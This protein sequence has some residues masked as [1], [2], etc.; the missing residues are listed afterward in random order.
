MFRSLMTSRRFA[1]LF[2]C[3]FFAAFN[4]NFLKS[5][6]AFL[7]LFK[8]GSAGSAS[9]VTLGGAVFIA[10][11]FL[12]SGLA[13]ELADRFDKAIIAERLKRSEIGAAAVA[14]VGFLLNSVPVLFLALFLFGVLAAL[15]GPV[16]YGLLPDKLRR[17]ELPAGNA[18]IEGA[19]FLAILFGTIAGGLAVAEE[20]QRR[21]LRRRGH[22]LRA[23]S[24]GSRAAAFR[25]AAGRRPNLV[26]ERNIV[27]STVRPAE[28]CPAR[29]QDLA[30]Q[31][32]GRLV[33]DGRRGRPLAP[34]DPGQGRPRRRR[35]GGHRLSRALL[36]RHRARLGHRRVA[37]ERPH[38]PFADPGRGIAMGLFMLDVGFVALNAAP[39]R[40]RGSSRSSR[41]DQASTSRSISSVL[42][43]P[44]ASS[45]CPPS[46][47][48]RRGAKRP[49]APASS[50]PSMSC[51]R[52]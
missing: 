38:R 33:L 7:L 10:P 12:L 52:S 34:A 24:P 8:L 51:R 1:P 6:L 26:V 22:G 27:R 5:A 36:D 2:W 28:A 37:R 23:C 43:S 44:G 19:T 20:R 30:R 9:L 18:L 45:S 13:G 39:P 25:R 35:G 47:P 16:K 29:H 40:S 17:E 41:P 3:Q 32:D 42:P 50:P 31:P 11:S 15:F 46:P 49:N 21:R 14:A 48:S 4:D